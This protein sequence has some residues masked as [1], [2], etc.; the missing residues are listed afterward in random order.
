MI[1][2]NSL[3]DFLII[4]KKKIALTIIL[5]PAFYVFYFVT[6][7]FEQPIISFIFFPPILSDFLIDI[8]FSNFGLYEKLYSIGWNESRFFGNFIMPLDIILDIL[9]IYFI[10]CFLVFTEKKFRQNKGEI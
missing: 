8:F 1:T 5:L 4:T 7:I 3:I 6:L 9:Y 2:K 10:S